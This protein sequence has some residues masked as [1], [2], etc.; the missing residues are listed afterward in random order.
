MNRRGIIF[1]FTAMLLALAVLG[2]SGI[3]T[4]MESMNAQKNAQMNSVKLVNEKFMEIGSS[5]TALER[6]GKAK[7]IQERALPFDYEVD[8]NALVLSH[9]LPLSEARVISFFDAV[10]VYLLFVSD[11]NYANAFSGLSVDVNSIRNSFWGG[12]DSNASFIVQP[13]CLEVKIFDLN[14]EFGKKNCAAKTFSAAAD[15]KRADLNI[16]IGAG[17]DYNSVSCI[18]NGAA[19]CPTD[20]FN[21][22]SSLPYFSLNIDDTNCSGCLPDGS[23]SI[24]WHFDPALEN[25]ITVSCIGGT[26]S[27]KPIELVFGE[28]LREMHSGQAVEVHSRIE[29]RKKLEAFEFNDFNYS[30]SIR[31]FNLMIKNRDE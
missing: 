27:S 4:S 18:S 31:D 23:E 13:F 1:S 11:K 2:L 19:V 22:P 28:L 5:A 26:C 15:V 12:A 25:S 30:V 10:N 21:P 16:F 29:F 20:S 24:S 17:E 14:F 8:G 9:M 3:G 7:E 6:D